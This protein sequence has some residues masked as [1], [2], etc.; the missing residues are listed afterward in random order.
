MK[1]FSSESFPIKVVV[2]I[3]ALSLSHLVSGCVTRPIRTI[4]GILRTTPM[5]DVNEGAIR[6]DD[7]L[8]R[9]YKYCNQ[10]LEERDAFAISLVV[11]LL[12]LPEDF[13]DKTF[14]IHFNGI[15]I[16]DAFYELAR[17]TGTRVEFTKRGVFIFSGNITHNTP[18]PDGGDSEEP[19]YDEDE[20]K[21]KGQ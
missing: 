8:D 14:E 2:F 18:S 21:V 13:K 10:K 12:S 1:L 11:D 15:S 16:Y 6:F 4:T 20:I 17:Q 7:I 9:L 19:V 5:E 3:L